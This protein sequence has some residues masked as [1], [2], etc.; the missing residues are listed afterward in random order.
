MKIVSKYKKINCAI[1]K[2]M[3]AAKPNGFEG[4]A[5]ESSTGWQQKAYQLLKTLTKTVQCKT[6]VIK[7]SCLLTESTTVLNQGTE[8]HQDPYNFL[9]EKDETI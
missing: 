2:G 6:S 9:Q 4:S 8:Y 5:E 1:R 7:V 3:K